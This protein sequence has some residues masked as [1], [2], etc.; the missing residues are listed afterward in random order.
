MLGNC[1][2]VCTEHLQLQN[3]KNTSQDKVSL[4]PRGLFPSDGVLLGPLMSEHLQ[5]GVV[6]ASPTMNTTPDSLSVRSLGR[7]CLW[8]VSVTEVESLKIGFG[9]SVT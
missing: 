6:S 2:E 5:G 4:L 1:E 7:I 8:L 3:D 9:D